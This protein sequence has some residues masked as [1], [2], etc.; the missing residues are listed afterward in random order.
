M[1]DWVGILATF[2][3]RD[4]SLWITEVWY[5]FSKS[6]VK[7][8]PDFV[9]NAQI[10]YVI[11]NVM[12]PTT[13]IAWTE[14]PMGNFRIACIVDNSEYVPPF[15]CN[16]SFSLWDTGMK[17]HICL[18]QDLLLQIQIFKDEEV[19]LVTGIWGQVSPLGIV[20][21]KLNIKDD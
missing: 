10:D 21:I 7:N 20:S 13:K 2:Q 15:G 3:A 8:P 11:P 19:K 4:I 5:E 16:K 17:D 12:V 18:H 6:K 14:A 9:P 1:I